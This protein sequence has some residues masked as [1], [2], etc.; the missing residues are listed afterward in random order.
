MQVVLAG[1][2][3]MIGSGLEGRLAAASHGLR[4]LVRP[5]SAPREGVESATWDPD[6]DVLDPAAFAGADAVVFLGGANI[7]DRPWSES[8]RRLLWDSRVRGTAL[9]A[10]TLAAMP[11]PPKT[12]LCASAIGYY[13]DQQDRLLSESA[14]PGSGFLAELCRAWEVAAEPAR[15]A[16]VRVIHARIGVVLDAHRGALAKMLPPFR[17]GLGGRI[18]SGRQ[19]FS[20][21]AAD[22]AVAAL[23]HCLTGPQIRGPVN[24]VAPESVPQAT[25]AATLARVLRRPCVLPLP[26]PMV[27]LLL[28]EMGRSLL[29]SS[30]RVSPDCLMNAGFAFRYPRLEDALR[31]LLESRRFDPTE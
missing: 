6:R 10:R 29:L 28:G 2:S 27:S 5:G 11:D 24:L 23:A 14:G 26:A 7:A 17:M 1:C 22:D 30:T 16:G 15:L 25:F 8:V 13:G 20:W 9:I 21:I 4:I 12:F 19:Y 18:G 31:A 3:G